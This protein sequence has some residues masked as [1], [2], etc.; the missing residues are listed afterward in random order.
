MQLARRLC[1]K[2]A[3]LLDVLKAIES[4]DKTI[5]DVRSHD[6]VKS[7]YIPN[8]VHIPLPDLIESP[9]IVKEH[10]SPIIFYC[11][12]GVRSFQ[13]ASLAEKEG[14]DAFNYQGSFD[15]YA[16]KCKDLIDQ[17]PCKHGK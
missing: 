12:A 7:G 11:K 2:N 14:I 15:E 17:Y 9:A 16:T 8:S 4:K 5:I 6:E 13:A 1:V 3:T 10:K